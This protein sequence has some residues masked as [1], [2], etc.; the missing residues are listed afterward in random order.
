MK[1]LTHLPTYVT[2][3]FLATTIVTFV[4]VVFIL[5]QAADR[6]AEPTIRHKI[7][8]G[9]VLLVLWMAIQGLLAYSGFYLD[10]DSLPPKF[11]VF[12]VGPT[13]LL[14][15]GGA[16]LLPR[17]NRLVASMSLA[18]ITYLHTVRL[19]VEIVLWW[20]YSYGAIPLVMTF[21]GRNFDI[22]VGITAPVIGYF[23]FTTKQWP[24][25]V[26]LVWNMLALV[27]LLNIVGHA[28]LSAPTPFQQFGLE[29]PNV[30]VLYFPFIWLGILIVPAVFLGHMIA[31]RRLWLK[32]QPVPYKIV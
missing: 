25:S 27:L 21:E 26:A 8:L 12:G 19:P 29:Q 7:N 24:R 5:Y 13:L 11:A 28:I 4:T 22:L 3:T 20:L 31:I 15:I 16:M 10:F 32:N 6:L 17:A 14:M 9:L 2:L 1:M 30:A 18:T 23:C